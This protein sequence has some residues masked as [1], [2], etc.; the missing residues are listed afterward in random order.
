MYSAESV[1]HGKGLMPNIA[2][3]DIFPFPMKAENEEIKNVP[4]S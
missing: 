2:T 4:Y 1:H 3:Q